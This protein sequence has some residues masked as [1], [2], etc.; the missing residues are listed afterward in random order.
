MRHTLTEHEWYGLYAHDPSRALWKTVIASIQAGKLSPNAAKSRGYTLLHAATASHCDVSVMKQLLRL[1]ADPSAA[2]DFWRTPLHWTML[3]AHA[4][5]AE[6]TLNICRMLPVKD[7]NKRDTFGITPLF[8]LITESIDHQCS[9]VIKSLIPVLTWT[10]EQPKCD[11]E[12]VGNDGRTPLEF[13]VGH[14][15]YELANIIA[16][17]I[18][19]RKRWT[20]ARAAWIAAVQMYTC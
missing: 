13:C 20:P 6:D 12:A 16:A 8:F 17:A 19:A 3:H 7:L 1:G 11:L 2:D 18:A 9:V 10:L 15:K 5:I 14:S 4:R